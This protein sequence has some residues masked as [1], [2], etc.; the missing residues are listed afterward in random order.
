MSDTI[1]LRRGDDLTALHRTEFDSE[2]A[3]QAMLARY[4]DLLA[5]EQMTPEDPRRWL[6]IAREMGVPDA[7]GGPDRWSLD[8]LFVDNDAVPTLVEVKRASDTRIRRE[9]AGQMLDY[10]SNA[11]TYW[12]I[13]VVRA[14]FEQS[15]RAR[16]TDP[17][18]AVAELIRAGADMVNCAGGG[19]E[20]WGVGSDHV[21]EAVEGFWSRLETNLQAGRIRMVFV[22]DHIPEELRRIVEFL[23]RQMHL[24]EVL[25]VEIPQ[26]V[27]ADVQTLVPR[28]YGMTAEARTRKRTS[29]SAAPAESWSEAEFFPELEANAQPE[30][31][32]AARALLDW[33]KANGR[34]VDWTAFGFVPVLPVGQKGLYSFQV[35]PNGNVQIYFQYLK[36]RPPFNNEAKRREL[37]ARL[38]TIPG[39]AI[40]PEAI[41]GKPTVPLV[42]L[43]S[44]D[45]IG[46]FLDV[47]NWVRREVE[48]AV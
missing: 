26:F 9:V 40:A 32:K 3:L 12:P 41:G 39:I 23:N 17:L 21:R 15:A 28:V 10:A 47:V 46:R 4:P 8:H 27:G 30:A 19:S 38:N 14:T 16:G 6:L 11:V 18:R 33:A 48:L 44:Q 35:L 36:A 31:A 29:T 37:L 43:A 42:A 24:A 20:A 7:E 13:A 34:Q 2:D 25:A 22:A 1:F 45:N 5:G